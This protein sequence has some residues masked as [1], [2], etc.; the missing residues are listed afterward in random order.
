MS[1]IFSGEWWNQLNTGEQ[2]FWGTAIISTI[3]FLLQT[4]MTFLGMDSHGDVDVDTGGDVD[5][6]FDGDL[7]GDLE[8]DGGDGGHFGVDHDFRVFSIRSIIA[9]FTFFSWGG[10]LILNAG[11]S[12]YLAILVGLGFGLSAMFFVAWVLFKVANLTEVGTEDLSLAIGQTGEVYIPIPR[13]RT[14]KGR[15]QIIISQGIKEL[16]AITN[17][18]RI[19]TG[20]KV[21]VLDILPDNVLIVERKKSYP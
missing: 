16:D 3:L 20:E 2:F 21:I 4:I 12:I 10:I 1:A 14:G 19:S 17:D 5:I 15:I 7:E 8:T 6:D 9:F 18:T 11:L 13:E